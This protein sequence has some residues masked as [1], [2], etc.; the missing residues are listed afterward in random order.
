MW[1]WG[2]IGG[3]AAIG[4]ILIL[5]LMLLTVVVRLLGFHRRHALQVS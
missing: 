2:H 4:S 1:D 5:A 3:V